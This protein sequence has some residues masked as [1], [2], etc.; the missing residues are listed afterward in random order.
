MCGLAPVPDTPTLGTPPTR[1]L[2]AQAAS[3]PFRVDLEH[4][5]LALEHCGF[6]HNGRGTPAIGGRWGPLVLGGTKGFHKAKIFRRFVVTEVGAASEDPRQHIKPPHQ[7][8]PEP[9][10][11]ERSAYSSRS[12][13]SPRIDP[14]D[15]SHFDAPDGLQSTKKPVALSSLFLLTSMMRNV[16]QRKMLVKLWALEVLRVINE[17]T[18]AALAYGLDRA[19]SLVVAAYDLGS[20]ALLDFGAV[21][22][23]AIVA[24]YPTP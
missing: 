11:H 19:G 8:H 21:L 2:P 4:P 17:P 18:A 15:H 6:K 16:K 22:R 13:Q 23:L 24:M 20:G 12:P 3:A 7:H 5:T 1:R 10:P 9:I 14:H